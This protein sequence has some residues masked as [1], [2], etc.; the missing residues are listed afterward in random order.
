MLDL[1]DRQLR[2]VEYVCA[3][4]ACPENIYWDFEVRELLVT[5][6]QEVHAAVLTLGV[7][8]P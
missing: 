5:F 3:V 2:M 7:V 6:D 1:R 4:S 8:V